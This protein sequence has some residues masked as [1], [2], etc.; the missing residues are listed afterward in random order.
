MSSKSNAKFDSNVNEGPR[1]CRCMFC[2]EL[3]VL[4]CEE[5]AVEHMRTCKL[6]II[7]IFDKLICLLNLYLFYH[8]L[9]V[10]L[11]E[12]L[13]NTKNQFT[14]PKSVENEMKNKSK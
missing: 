5:E 3:L 12:Q 7:Y 9:G 2:G 10:A 13:S 4:Q 1:E 8:F 6:F 14:I 11:T